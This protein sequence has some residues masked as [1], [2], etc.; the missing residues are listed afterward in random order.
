MTERDPCER[1]EEMIQPYLD[2][3]LQP[4]EVAEAE[5]HLDTCVYYRR[6][7]RFELSLRRYI[8]VTASE[9]MPDG[10]KEKLAELRGLPGL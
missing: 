7:Y 6:R 1:C 9:R 10:L 8:R 4:A 3:D 5:R 2:R